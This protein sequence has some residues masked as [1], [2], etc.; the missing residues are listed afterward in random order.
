[1]RIRI[2]V[3]QMAALMISVPDYT[4]YNS[5]YLS[6]NFGVIFIA[7]QSLYAYLRVVDS[8]CTI[9]NYILRP[10]NVLP[11]RNHLLKSSRI[12]RHFILRLFI[13]K[14]MWIF[15]KTIIRNR[16]ISKC[17]RMKFENPKIFFSSRIGLFDLLLQIIMTHGKKRVKYN[18][19]LNFIFFKFL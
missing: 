10:K 19:K 11:S 15:F 6:I 14:L 1:M 9:F 13:L 3:H 16:K 18:G 5:C 4:F 7:R 8:F 12:N 17:G 2:S